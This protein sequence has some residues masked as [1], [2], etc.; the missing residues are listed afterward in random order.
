[1][2]I[3]I[4]VGME[5]EN[6]RTKQRPAQ[7]YSWLVPSYG[8]SV[9]LCCERIQNGPKTPRTLVDRPAELSEVATFWLS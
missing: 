5:Q 8:A 4:V 2:S 7:Q 9:L 1:M 6:E 3:H